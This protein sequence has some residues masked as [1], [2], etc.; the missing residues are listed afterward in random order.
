MIKLEDIALKDSLKFITCGSVDDGKSTF[1]GRLLYDSDALLDDQLENLIK[2]SAKSNNKGKD[3]LDF[4]LL[5]DGLSSE[6]E[7]GITIDVSYRFFSSQKR[8]FIVLDSPGHTEFTR[9]MAT[10]SSKV[11]LAFLIIDARKGV[12]EQ[13]LRHSYINALLGVKHISLLINKMDLVEF[14]EKTFTKIVNDYKRIIKDNELFKNINFS[15]FPISAIDGD[16][17]VNNSNNLDWYKGSTV[18]QFLENIDLTEDNSKENIAVVENVNRVNIDH[19][20]FGIKVLSGSLKKDDKIN[21]YPS[22]SNT[23]IKSIYNYSDELKTIKKDYVG[24]ITT[25]SEVEISHG[26]IISNNDDFLE[27]NNFST[28][29]IWL[30]NSKLINNKEYLFISKMGIFLGN[31]TCKNNIDITTFKEID[32][33]NVKLNTIFNGY[34]HLNT[35]IFAKKYRDCKELGSLIAVDK[36]TNMT[37]A[38]IIIND[39]S[40]KEKINI[41]NIVESKFDITKDMRAELKEQKPITIWLTGISGAGKSTI[42]NNLEKILYQNRKHTMVLDGDNIRKGINSN[43]GFSDS[44]RSENIRRVAHIAKLFND[45]GTIAIVSLISP[46]QSDRDYAKDVIGKD[47]FF[48]VF[49]KADIETCVKRDPKGLYNK[50]IKNFT[51]IDSNYE[52]PKNADL[53]IDTTKNNIENSLKLIFNFIKEKI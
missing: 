24:Y 2:D 39:K 21:I 20:A 45:S 22:R 50:K 23:T 41:N 49:I 34:I 51:G 3:G 13:T 48:E 8:K 18:L 37:V 25:S 5:L 29:A 12:L 40:N 19:R 47:S 1:I 36:F 44:D 7:Q 4:S 42:A 14:S 27:S 31:I 28:T 32:D 52:D 43:L 15:Y 38:A 16:N 30:D 11:D 17:I 10:A 35:T 6:R 33:H 9:N 46:K 26:S 53:V